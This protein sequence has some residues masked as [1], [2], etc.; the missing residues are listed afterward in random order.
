MSTDEKIMTLHPRGKKGVNI[1]REKYDQIRDFIYFILEKKGVIS[2]QDLNDM[3]VEQL[4]NSFDGKVPWYLVTVKL[5][6]EARGEIERV[7]GTS[8]HEVRFKT[9]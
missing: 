5:D 7:P 2:Y 4:T 3:A 9:D 1:S 8:P 6:L